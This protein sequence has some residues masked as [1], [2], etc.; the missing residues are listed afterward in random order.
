MVDR[1]IGIVG[2]AIS[3]IVGLLSFL[4]RAMPSWMALAGIAIGVLLLGISI[5]LVI[6]HR[7]TSRKLSPIVDNALLRLHIYPDHRTPDKIA[8][9][10]IFRWYFLKTIISM[11]APDGAQFEPVTVTLFVA[12]DPEVR[13]TTLRIN[14]PDIQL[15]PHEVKEFNQRF[16]IVTFSGKIAEGTLEMS[17]SP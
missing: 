13:I 8:A 17:V 9:Q 15:P 4:I 10:N 6:G 3:I 11:H 16:A 12:F 2:I 5:G 14:S 1:A 7:R